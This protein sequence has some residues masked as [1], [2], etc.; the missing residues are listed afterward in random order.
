VIP[1]APFL[2]VAP[3]WVC[4]IVSPSTETLD[5]VKKLAIYARQSTRHSWLINPITRTLEVLQLEA[6]RWVL[7][8][9]HDGSALVRAAPFDA[10]DL[11]LAALWSGVPAPGDA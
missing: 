3:D 4:E 7:L 5:R 9:V 11:D 8:A 2:T 10:V 6:G 1:S